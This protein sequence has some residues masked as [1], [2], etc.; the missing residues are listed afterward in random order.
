ML[1]YQNFVIGPLDN[2][3]VVLFDDDSKEGAVIDP[4][5]DA[6]PVVDFIQSKGLTINTIYLTHAHFD[7]YYGL[8]YLR[9][10]LPEIQHVYLHTADLDLWN[11]GGGAQKFLTS[12]IH[13]PQPDK[14][15]HQEENLYLGN[16]VLKVLHTPGHTPGSVVYYSPEIS[17]AFCG[18]LIFYHGIGR[19]DL[20]GGNYRQLKESIQNKIFTLPLQTT[21]ISGH[22][23]ITNVGEELGNNPFFQ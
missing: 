23:P 22:G 7:H 14:I 15:I 16:Y 1:E 12:V 2:N 6:D 18:D 4:S 13:L 3:C 17:T 8:P 11:E 5:F 21:L 19:T 9:S 20:L 10:V